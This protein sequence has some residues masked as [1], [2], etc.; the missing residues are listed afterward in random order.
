MKKFSGAIL[1]HSNSSEQE[2]V[3]LLNNKVNMNL[4]KRF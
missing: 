1:I 4:N 2:R 3:S